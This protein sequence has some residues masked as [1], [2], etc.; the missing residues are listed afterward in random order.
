MYPILHDVYFLF[1]SSFMQYALEYKNV[2]GTKK[3]KR[4]CFEKQK[5]VLVWAQRNL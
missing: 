2:R 5:P 4:I 1:I 3:V